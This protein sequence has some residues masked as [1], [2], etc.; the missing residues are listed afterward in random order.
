MNGKNKSR[1]EH[2]EKI[3][4]GLKF[5]FF[6]WLGH[7]LGPSPKRGPAEAG[8]GPE[9]KPG[10]LN[11]PG[12]APWVGYGKTWPKPDPLP[13]LLQM[14]LKWGPANLFNTSKTIFFNKK[15]RAC[16]HIRMM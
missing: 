8:L 14:E 12:L 3:N 16:A 13:F 4:L 1:L 15:A 10:T 2:K 9:K 7:E 11:G 5:F 6:F